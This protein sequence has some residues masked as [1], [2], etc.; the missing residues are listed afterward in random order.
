MS[1]VE[2]RRLGSVVGLGTYGTFRRDRRLARRVVG[3]ALD[4]GAR[5][6][7]TSPMY[8][9]EDAL[10]SALD[11]RRS[12]AT[13]ATK[14]WTPSVDEGQRQFEDQLRFFEH[15]EIE[16]VHNLVAW[17]EHLPWLERERDAGRLDL[18]GVTHW[19][20]GA[21]AVLERALETGRFDTVQVPLNPFERECERRILPLAESRGIA[22]I[23]MRPLGGSEG[24]RL[25]REPPE[26]ELEPLRPFGVETWPQ[27][28][29]KWAL[30][31]RRVDLVIPASSRPE[32]AEENARAGSPPWFS[33]EERRLVE[34]LAGA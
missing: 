8:D 30:S 31:D 28:L 17:R 26:R 33:A 3:A 29:L 32:R 11:G 27:A 5:V 1:R 23:A 25:R 9:S 15:V 24:L 16:Q 13:V 12:A 19:S 21:F 22:V 18:F 14:I 4:S 7:D 34:R 10:G 6:F 2:E 20:A